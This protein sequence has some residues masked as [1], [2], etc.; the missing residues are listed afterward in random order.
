MAVQMAVPKVEMRDVLMAAM[1][2]QTMDL[3]SAAL[4]ASQMVDQTALQ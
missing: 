1:T 3:H 2:V 4:T